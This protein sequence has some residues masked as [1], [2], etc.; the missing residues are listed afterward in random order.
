[1]KRYPILGAVAMWAALL[2]AALLSAAPVLAAAPSAGPP[3][4]APV[5]S[6]RVYDYAGIFTPETISRAEAI[7]SGIQQRTGA[8]IAVYTQLKPES[9]TLELANADARALMDQWGVGRKGFDDGLVIMFDMQPNLRHGEVSLYAGA[10]YKAAF[11]SDSDRQD[12]FDN[13]MKPL[14]VAGDMD[15]ALLAGLRAVE[16]N[17][18]PEHAATLER[19]RQINA[20]FF[21]AG[22]LLGPV[23]ILLAFLRWLRHGRDPVYMDDNSILM[24]APP[25]GLTPPMATLL[26]EDRT[27]DRN[28]T[29]ALVD[30]AAQGRISFKQERDWTGDKPV[31][32]GIAYVGEGTGPEDDLEGKVLKSIASH[33]QKTD[34]VIVST[35]L[36]HLIPAFDDLKSGLEKAAVAKGWLSEAPDAVVWRWGLI[37]GLELTVAIVTA[38]LWLIFEAS[39]LLIVTAGLILAGV[40]TIAMARYMPARTRQGAMLYAMLSAYKRTLGLS[41]TGSLSMD[42]VVKKH[43]VPWITTP[44]QAMVWGIA[45]GLDDELQVVLA[46]SLKQ[47]IDEDEDSLDPNAWRPTWWTVASGGH[48]HS[49][50]SSGVSVGLSSPSAGIFS[51]SLIPNAGAIMAALGSIAS[52]VSPVSSSSGGGSSSSFGSSSFGGG[53]GGGGGGAGG[54]F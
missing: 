52:P 17:A 11:M 25:A 49:S 44:D 47:G 45:F 6:Q 36:Y 24:P 10:G 33:G 19:G 7:I 27:S 28:V 3:Y 12:V 22:V 1:V 29:A 37:G 54:G 50:H 15:G 34:N 18:T 31:H 8:Q 46:H 41:M 32:V 13:T 5:E 42:E 30:L 9:D 21:L 35:R 4:P 48:G 2:L 23:L 40:V 38:I 51:S 14:L 26:L 20:I 43:A 53:G 39:G 16:A